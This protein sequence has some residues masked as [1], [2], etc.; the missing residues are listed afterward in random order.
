MKIIFICTR[1]ITF[2]TFLISQ[3]NFFKKKKINV[4]VACSDIEKLKFSNRFNYRIDFPT[5]YIHFLNLYRYVKIFFQ[6]Q[7]LVKKNQSSIFYLHTPVAAY[8]FRFFTFF[9]NLKII[10]F[11]HGFR[12]T[13]KTKLIT[14]FFYKF[15]EKL[16]SFKTK[17]FLTINNE[18]YNY[19]KNNLFN[20][21]PT[22]KINGV[23]LDLQKSKINKNHNN[24]INKIIVIAAYK[25]SKGYL[26]ILKVAEILK[27]E[28]IKID[29]YGYGDYSDYKSIKILKK[30]KNISFYKFD[31][32]LKKKI[33]KYHILLHLSERE[34]LPVSVMECLSK[35]IPV[36]CYK[37]RG[38]VDLI[39]NNWNGYFIKSYLEVP[40]LINKLNFKEKLLNKI[41]I[42][43]IKSITKSFSKKQ[44]NQKIY[45]IIKKNFK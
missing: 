5:K 17:I 1:S 3:V 13:S 36:I 37:I 25:K 15:I 34:G 32:N 18:D 38:N 40:K 44:V 33:K 41:Q 29:C 4:K 35:G 7:N 19:A 43:A 24:K 26:E 30:L 27:K 42:N 14:A 31:T 20:K 9:Y 23:G 2:N 28:K 6:I 16:L 12:F 11:V 10:Y 21:V 45:R 39:K 8:I 22:Y